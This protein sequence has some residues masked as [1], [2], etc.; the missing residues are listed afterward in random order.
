M[1]KDS[2]VSPVVGTGPGP[3]TAAISSRVYASQ[4]MAVRAVGHDNN[5]NL[6]RMIAAASVLISHASLIARGQGP[7]P[8]ERWLHGTTLG[9]V[10]VYIFFAISG[11]F[12]TR[13]YEQRHDPYDFRKARLLRLLP[14]LFVMCCVT[15]IAGA[16]LTTVPMSVYLP[17]ALRY[18]LHNATVVSLQSRLAGVFESSPRAINGSLWT[19]FYEVLCYAAVF[20]AG[21][22]GVLRRRWLT[23]PAALLF[24]CG[25]AAY[26]EMPLRIW[27][28][29]KLGLAFLIGG[30]IWIWRDR[31]PFS[32]PL[33][34]A[35]V[36]A[37]V[38]AWW[39]PVFIPV[40][41][42]AISYG[43]LL[44]GY[45][46]T[47]SLRAYNRLGDYSYGIYIYAFPIQ[48][49]AA[50]LGARDPWSNVLVALP[51]TFCCAALSW[52][53]VEKPT[54]ALGRRK[55]AARGET[56]KVSE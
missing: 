23:L 45:A 13:S 47:P 26:G 42:L 6:I 33:A 8:L 12:I 56:N 32:W 31:V 51:L 48:Q 4:T 25:Y 54:Q 55:P 9:T 37:A 38:A 29:F 15:V 22:A 18:V 24:L 41:V 39:T 7:E 27:L 5:F 10:G 14:G 44:L 2:G 34:G 50:H 19:L 49:L 20:L 11:F 21:L 17:D 30:M 46:D 28:F 53:L 36:L 1:L 40:M 16:F 43:V 35:F 3:M 52:A